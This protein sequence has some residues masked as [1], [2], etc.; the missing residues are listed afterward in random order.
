MGNAQETSIPRS[1]CPKTSGRMFRTRPNI[2]AI[3]V[4][5][6][7]VS[8]TS[9]GFGQWHIAKIS[10]VRAAAAHSLRTSDIMRLCSSEL[11]ATCCSK[12]NPK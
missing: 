7:N 2:H 12:Q 3:A 4:P 8:G 10:P 11:S 6:K 5:P 9:T 1:T